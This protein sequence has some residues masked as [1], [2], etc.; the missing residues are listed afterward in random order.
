MLPDFLEMLSMYF[1]VGMYCLNPVGQHQKNAELGFGST[2][3]NKKAT[4]L[5][6]PLFFFGSCGVWVKRTA[7]PQ[8]GGVQLSLA[9]ELGFGG[10]FHPNTT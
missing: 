1:L 3:P 6:K 7:E 4:C 9:A 2:L 5:R 10:T 8:F